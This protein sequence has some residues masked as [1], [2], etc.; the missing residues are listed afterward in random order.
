M[1]IEN[2]GGSIRLEWNEPNGA[3]EYIVYRNGGVL[4]QIPSL[5]YF[6]MNDLVSNGEYCY[7]IQALY[8]GDPT[9]E[10]NEFCLSYQPNAPNNLDL[11]SGNRIISLSWDLYGTGLVST[12][13]I[14]DGQF[15]GETTEFMFVDSDVLEGNN[16]CYEVYSIYQFGESESVSIC[17]AATYSSN[18]SNYIESNTSSI[19]TMDLEYPITEIYSPNNGD[20]VNS[21]NML[22]RYLSYFLHSFISLDS[23]NKILLRN[24]KIFLNFLEESKERI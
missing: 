23:L 17:G 16:Y 1:S 18:P 11:Y 3:T 2:F 5:I 4:D 7:S 12:N 9:F 14:R 6:D 21:G 10:S 8:D 19:F 22:D 15:I 13:I 20:M 24:L